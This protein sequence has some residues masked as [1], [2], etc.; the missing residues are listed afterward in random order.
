MP[1]PSHLDLTICCIL[2]YYQFT[3][4][5]SSLSNS[6]PR[7]FSPFSIPYILYSRFFLNV[8]ESRGTLLLLYPTWRK[9]GTLWIDCLGLENVWTFCRREISLAPVSLFRTDVS[10]AVRIRIVTLT[11]LPTRS[12]YEHSKSFDGSQVFWAL[13]INAFWIVYMIP[14]RPKVTRSV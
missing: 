8:D 10:T 5:G 1:S 2:I 13:H 3:L 4:P 14:A 11:S 6:L 9:V 12:Q 7:L